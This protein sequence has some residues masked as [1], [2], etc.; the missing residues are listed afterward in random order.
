MIG[1]L[2]R[3]VI[4]VFGTPVTRVVGYPLKF[5]ETFLTITIK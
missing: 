3:H 5:Y 2:D 4:G 1:V